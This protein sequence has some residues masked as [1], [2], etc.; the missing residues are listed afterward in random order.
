MIGLQKLLSLGGGLL[1]AAQAVLIVLQG[2]ILCLN[3]GC[4]IVEKLTTVPPI[5]F[6]VAGSLFFMALFFALWQ[7]G[8]TVTGGLGLARLLLLAG[9]AVEGVLVGFQYYVAEAFCSYCLIVFSIIAVLNILMGWRQLLTS[10]AVFGAVLLA[11]ASL[12]FTPHSESEGMALDKG[13]YGHLERQQSRNEL[14]LFFSSTCPHCEDVIATIDSTFACSLNFNPIDTL[15]AAP[16]AGLQLSAAYSPAIN[17]GYLKNLGI[18]EIPIL[19]IK[20]EGEIRILKGKQMIQEYL[21]AA[22][23]DTAGT[24]DD[25]I[26]VSGASGQST[27]LPLFPSE[28]QQETCTVDEACEEGAPG[29]APKGAGQGQ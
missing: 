10:A 14:Y 25:Q 23:R 17:R 13:I 12:Q 29:E 16:L 2:D 9:T 5:A 18:S 22:C 26:D 4:E 27:V 19:V 11:F 8:R 20:K 15:E 1:A 6:N 7:G 28:S 21:D 24:A 3:D